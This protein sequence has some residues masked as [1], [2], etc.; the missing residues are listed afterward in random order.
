MCFFFSSKYSDIENDKLVYGTLML[1]ELCEQFEK[2]LL[3]RNKDI[4]KNVTDSES[5]EKFRKEQNFIH[6]FGFKRAVELGLIQGHIESS[7]KSVNSSGD[8]SDEDGRE[9]T[10]KSTFPLW[11]VF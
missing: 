5:E 3:K 1:S 11:V 7:S 2:N 9:I 8:D 4:C 10:G 6:L